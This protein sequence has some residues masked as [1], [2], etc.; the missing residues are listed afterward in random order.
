MISSK[1]YVSMDALC[2]GMT[3]MSAYEHSYMNNALSISFKAIVL[4]ALLDKSL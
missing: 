2:L 3:A 4:L 1:F